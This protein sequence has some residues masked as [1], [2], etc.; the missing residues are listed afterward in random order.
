MFPSST[1]FRLRQ[2]APP[3][4]LRRHVR[5]IRLDIENRSS[6]QHIDTPDAQYRTLP[7]EQL[8]DC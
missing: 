5:E 1:G 6:V 4:S 7:A 3:Q 2:P 8:D